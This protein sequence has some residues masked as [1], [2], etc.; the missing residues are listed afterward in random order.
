MPDPVQTNHKYSP[1]LKE[2][3][4]LKDPQSIG[5]QNASFL[6]RLHFLLLLT[7]L[8]VLV[9]LYLS[10]PVGTLPFPSPGFLFLYFF[11]KILPT[12]LTLCVL[13]LILPV[14]FGTDIPTRLRS[15]RKEVNQG[16]GLVWQTCPF[17]VLVCFL[18]FAFQRTNANLSRCTVRFRK[19]HQFEN[20]YA[21]PY[22]VGFVFMSPWWKSRPSLGWLSS[23]AV[24]RKSP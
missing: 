4:V 14:L 20:K 7:G 2:H 1:C 9:A 6:R 15:G 16:H 11:L 5:G 3:V 8:F 10:L 24:E 23:L 18:C 12:C 22:G 17:L 19:E 13:L 21:Q